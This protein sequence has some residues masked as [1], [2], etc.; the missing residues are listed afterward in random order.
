MNALIFAGRLVAGAAWLT[1]LAAYTLPFWGA[2]L[3]VFWAAS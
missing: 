2:A 3:L 1:L